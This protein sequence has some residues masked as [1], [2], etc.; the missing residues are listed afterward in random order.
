M[1][2]WKLIVIIILYF[3]FFLSFYYYY[4]YYYF[5]SLLATKNL[6]N[7]LFFEILVSNF[8]SNLFFN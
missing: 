5:P 7:H 4:Y 1:R 6:Q 3:L 8:A 2:I